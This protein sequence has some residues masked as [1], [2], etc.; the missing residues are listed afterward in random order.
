MI[1]VGIT[2]YAEAGKS[3]VAD[4]LVEEHGFDRLS[5]AT[6]VKE[7]MRKMDP[8]LGGGQYD[9]YEHLEY[10]RLSTL[11]EDGYSEREIK[12]S[13]FGKEYRRL[14]K[15]FATECIREEDPDFWVRA[16][17]KK[18]T[19]PDGRYV[20]DDV[21]FPNEAHGLKYIP[22]EGRSF[23][24]GILVNV[25]RPGHDNGLTDGHESEE[26]AGRLDEN[27]RLLNN[28]TKEQLDSRVDMIMEHIL[29]YGQTTYA[30]S[31]N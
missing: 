13:R 3:T 5:F 17:L 23:T 4:R 10:V 12:D 16:A 18:L 24:R 30:L 31:D 25:I 27:M 28:S 6:P 15:T 20:F 7:M 26:W 19:N 11:L 29:E 9:D 8:I 14:I 2:G 1:V 22:G 21:R